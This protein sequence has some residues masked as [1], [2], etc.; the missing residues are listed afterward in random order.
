MADY[1]DWG[2]YAEWMPLNVEGMHRH[3]S[4]YRRGN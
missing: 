1:K 2:S 3:L 4:N